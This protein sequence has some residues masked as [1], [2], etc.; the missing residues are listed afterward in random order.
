MTYIP[1]AQVVTYVGNQQDIDIKALGYQ[2][3]E[4][5]FPQIMKSFITE[6]EDFVGYGGEVVP[7][8]MKQTVW[9]STV[10]NLTIQRLTEAFSM[11]YKIY[12]LQISA[13]NTVR[14]M[15]S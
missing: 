14:S 6:G 11:A 2:I 7:A 9:G 12:E 3:Y 4:K 1:P 13:D 8:D 10:Y 15:W 5:S